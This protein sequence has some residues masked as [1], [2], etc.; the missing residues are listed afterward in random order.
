MADHELGQSGL[1]SGQDLG[2]TS[3]QQWSTAVQRRM[4][5]H[6]QIRNIPPLQFGLVANGWTEY[7]YQ[8]WFM[9]ADRGVG[10]GQV[11]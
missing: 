9:D 6:D 8:G 10:Q 5:P 4:D 1:H 3:V 11:G 7:Q 2:W